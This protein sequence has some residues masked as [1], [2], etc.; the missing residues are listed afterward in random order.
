MWQWCISKDILL[1]AVHVPGL[2]NQKADFN[3]RHFNDR[4]E[5]SLHP[6]VFRWLTQATFNPDIDLF[7]SRLNN[8]LERFV[9]WLPDPD[10]F[11]CDAFSLRWHNFNGNA[12]PPF[13]LIP[14]VLVHARTDKIPRLLIIQGFKDF[15][16]P[17]RT[18]AYLASS[19]KLKFVVERRITTRK[20]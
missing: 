13:S 11:A 15:L 16:F 8:K 19:I 7:A 4:T 14:R 10:A 2:N 5:W 3:S 1:S 18:L 20:G 6:I 12:F 9:S 17:L